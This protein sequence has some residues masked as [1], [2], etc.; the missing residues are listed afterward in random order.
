MNAKLVELLGTSVSQPVP[1]FA[2]EGVHHVKHPVQRG[3]GYPLTK[4]ARFGVEIQLTFDINFKPNLGLGEW[5]RRG[6]GHLLFLGGWLDDL[7]LPLA[8]YFWHFGRSKGRGSLKVTPFA[9][10]VL[11]LFLIS[12]TSTSA[13]NESQL[14]LL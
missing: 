7:L 10:G 13:A 9:A 5:E 2:T 14:Q 8:F 6:V 12:G 11:E 1:N 3:H 4:R